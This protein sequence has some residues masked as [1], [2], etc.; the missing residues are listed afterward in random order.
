MCLSIKGIN[1]T[2][3]LGLPG[4]TPQTDR[5]LTKNNDPEWLRRYLA[6]IQ[7]LVAYYQRMGRSN[8]RYRNK[9]LLQAAVSRKRYRS[10]NISETVQDG[11]IF[12]PLTPTVA[13][14]VQL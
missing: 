3:L 9:S 11:D 13:I 2:Y 8:S 14:S 12:N 5:A 7:H 4:I 10:A 1:S 6:C